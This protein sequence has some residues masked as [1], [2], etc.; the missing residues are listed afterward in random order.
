MENIKQMQERHEAEIEELQNQ[1]KHEK[2]SDWMPYMWAPGHFGGDVRVC[3]F[4][5]VTVERKPYE[6]I[7]ATTEVSKDETL[8]WLMD[9][10]HMIERPDLE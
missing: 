5:G 8:K 6:R 3:E 7:Q 2:V 9:T 1:C 10:G 4:C